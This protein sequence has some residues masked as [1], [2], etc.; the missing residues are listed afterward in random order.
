M[1]IRINMAATA[2]LA[3]FLIPNGVALAAPDSGGAAATANECLSAPK[4]SETP[5][6]GHWYYRTDR[7][8]KRKCWFLGEASSKAS[9]S[10]ART[11][12]AKPSRSEAADP[13]AARKKADPA[14]KNSPQS[15]DDARAEMTGAEPASD[16]EKLQASVWPPMNDN[17]DA[18]AVTSDAGNAAPATQQIAQT[19]SQDRFAPAPTANAASPVPSAA[20]QPDRQQP[21]STSNASNAEAGKATQPPAATPPL[22]SPAPTSDGGSLR[23]MLAALACGL[24]L[25]I[26]L[27]G[28]AFKQFERRREGIRLADGGVSR[29]DIWSDAPA[30]MP[31]PAAAA[32][33]PVDLDEVARRTPER[34]DTDDEVSEPLVA[35]PSRRTAA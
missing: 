9:R 34:Q 2:M 28:F 8:T 10:A 24:G 3:C 20:P 26:I 32:P 23:P 11:A 17:S 30:E 7:T 35:Q 25:A 29:R 6:G 33:T 19:F 12:A 18:K 16:D 21:A 31:R 27:G 22:P 14:P 4:K 13:D 1:R 15:F 5:P